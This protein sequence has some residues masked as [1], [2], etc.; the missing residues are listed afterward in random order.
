MFNGAAAEADILPRAG[1]RVL[2]ARCLQQQLRH[3][4]A[5]H[6]EGLDLTFADI[7]ADARGAEIKNLRVGSDRDRLGNTCGMQLE[8]ETERTHGIQY[9]PIFLLITGEHVGC[10]G[11]DSR[12]GQIHR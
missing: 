2:G 4:T 7:G 6:G 10:C 8:I 3:L 11:L 9:W 1:A 5:I 12:G